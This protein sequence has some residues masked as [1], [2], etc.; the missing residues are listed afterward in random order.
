MLAMLTKQKALEMDDDEAKKLAE[1]LARVQR[2]FGVTVM[3]PK[4]AAL[5]NLGMVGLG[6]YGPRVVTMANEAAKKK[7]GKQ[8]VT[9]DA[10]PIGVTM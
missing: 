9:I 1:A 5:V 2:E 4:V 6:V 7:K 10:E 8:G 3:S